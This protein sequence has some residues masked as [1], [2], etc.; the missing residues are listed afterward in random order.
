[1]SWTEGKIHSV[2]D[3]LALRYSFFD[4]GSTF[5]GCND[6]HYSCC[7]SSLSV[8]VTF[9]DILGIALFKG[10]SSREVFEKYLRIRVNRDRN[11]KRY[12]GLGKWGVKL[13]LE[14]DTPCPFLV[15]GRCEIYS[16]DSPVSNG[17]RPITCAT[18]PKIYS[19]SRCF[20]L[21]EEDLASFIWAIDYF[22]P[23]FPCVTMGEITDER[24]NTLLALK[25]VFN[26]VA[27]ATDSLAFGCAPFCLGLENAP[28]IRDA[29]VQQFF[30]AEISLKEHLQDVER[31]TGI[32]RNCITEERRD[33]IEKIEIFINSLDSQ[34][35]ISAS[36]M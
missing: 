10:L 21:S 6:C 22:S 32:I 11:L 27:A 2:D 18:F 20:E 30:N 3:L 24:A 9:A 23:V 5:H 8:D 1:M 34:R 29:G 16:T 28:F 13:S 12:A 19:F 26:Q 7:A 36:T 17:G 35:P 4:F 31:I 33:I 14:L 25:R 15:S